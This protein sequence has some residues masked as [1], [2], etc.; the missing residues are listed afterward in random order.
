MPGSCQAN[1]AAS[2]SRSEFQNSHGK[3]QAGIGTEEKKRLEQN[4]VIR[5]GKKPHTILE[6]AVDSIYRMEQTVKVSFGELGANHPVS[7]VKVIDQG[8]LLILQE[9]PRTADSQ[10]H[11][12]SQRNSPRNGQT[13]RTFA[14][15]SF[16][17]V[18]GDPEGLRSNRCNFEEKVSRFVFA[19]RLHSPPSM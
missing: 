2:K 19:F 13:T 18:Y 10:F 11:C 17:I 7:H 8:Q 16:G 3:V 15:F 1:V 12:I 4:L 6:D 9:F 14:L 5:G